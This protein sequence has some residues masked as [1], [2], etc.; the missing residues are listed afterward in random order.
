MSGGN[1]KVP[2]QANIKKEFIA[3]TSQADFERDEAN[4]LD[5]DYDQEYESEDDDGASNSDDAGSFYQ[6]TLIAKSTTP[7]S[8]KKKKKKKKN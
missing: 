4:P 1:L 3:T 8:S 2:L 7:A 5:D 6:P